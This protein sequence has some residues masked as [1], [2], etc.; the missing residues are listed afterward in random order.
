[1]GKDTGE[2]ERNPL[3]E[4]AEVKNGPSSPGKGGCDTNYGGS[5]DADFNRILEASLW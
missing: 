4:S 1:M 5:S 3:Y 2:G